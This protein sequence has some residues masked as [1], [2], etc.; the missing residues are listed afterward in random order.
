[1]DALYPL[2]SSGKSVRELVT[3]G[4][5]Q[6]YSQTTPEQIRDLFY[7]HPDRFDRPINAV[8]H[9]CFKAMAAIGYCYGKQVFCFPWM[10]RRRFDCFS[11]HLSELPHI[12]SDLKC[13]VILP[14]GRE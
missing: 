10:S 6:S 7:I 2:F 5:A 3:I 8:G 12:L 9:E 14:V 1:M 11:R 13:T 4:L